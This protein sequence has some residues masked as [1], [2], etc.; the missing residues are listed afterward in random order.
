MTKLALAIT[1]VA[2]AGIASHA[3]ATPASCVHV[4]AAAAD[5]AAELRRALAVELPGLP[6]TCLDVSLVAVDAV[7]DAAGVVLTAHVRVVVI[8]AAD[9]IV[10]VVAGQAT[11]RAGKRDAARRRSLLQHDVLD[12]AIASVVPTVRAHLRQHQLPPA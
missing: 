3:H 2:A 9:H 11:L 4:T 7:E 12:E 10:A 6:R 5:D 1:L 8:D